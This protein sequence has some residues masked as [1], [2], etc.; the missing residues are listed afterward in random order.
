MYTVAGYTKYMAYVAKTMEV[1]PDVSNHK[2]IICNKLEVQKHDEL[3][4]EEGDV[5]YEESDCQDDGLIKA[6]INFHKMEIGK[7]DVVDK[8]ELLEATTMTP[9]DKLLRWHH[10]L[11]HV[12]MI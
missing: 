4:I 5:V 11:S 6:N 8:E 1:F 2:L 3:I 7:F 9:E 10:R 12:S